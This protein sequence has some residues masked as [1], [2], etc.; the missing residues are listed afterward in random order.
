MTHTP[1]TCPVC[2]PIITT[3]AYRRGAA[4]ASAAVAGAPYVPDPAELL[5]AGPPC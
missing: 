5:K 4:K 2:A 3:S 1:D